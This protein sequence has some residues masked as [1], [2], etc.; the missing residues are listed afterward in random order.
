M[1]VKPN[2]DTLTAL[3]RIGKTA[4]WGIIEG[5]LRESRERYVNASLDPDPARSRQMQGAM[6]AIDELLVTIRAA[7]DLTTRR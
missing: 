3:G 2:P 4:E 1:L 7:V 5:W 6:V